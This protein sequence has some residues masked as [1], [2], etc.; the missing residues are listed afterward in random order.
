M[1]ALGR[2]FAG[3][4]MLMLALCAGQV[5]ADS[6]TG[7]YEFHQLPTSGISLHPTILAGETVYYAA[8]R[9]WL[10]ARDLGCRCQSSR[11]PGG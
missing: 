1:N 6:V 9:R 4:A 8:S 7:T 2:R 10:E 3:F 11:A 5:W